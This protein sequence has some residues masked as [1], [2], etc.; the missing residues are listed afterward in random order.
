MDAEFADMQKEGVAYQA[1][2]QAI[3]FK[4]SLLRTAITGS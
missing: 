3:S 2:S 4:F 1:A